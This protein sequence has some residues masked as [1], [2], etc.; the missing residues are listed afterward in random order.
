VGQFAEINLL[1]AQAALLQSPSVQTGGGQPSA[2]AS[3]SAGP[4]TH[5]AVEEFGLAFMNRYATRVVGNV[6]PTV[7]FTPVARSLTQFSHMTLV[8]GEN[9]EVFVDY[10]T[11]TIDAN[12][13]NS[14]PD[15]NTYPSN[16]FCAADWC[17]PEWRLPLFE[18]RSLGGG[19]RGLA[20]TGL[21]NAGTNMIIHYD[22]DDHMGMTRV[23]ME[24]CD[25][26][27][28]TNQA[29]CEAVTQVILPDGT[30]AVPVGNV[31]GLLQFYAPYAY[32]TTS[33][34]SKNFYTIDLWID[35]PEFR[36]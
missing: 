22:G 4:G 5:Y 36:R 2:P 26:P 13:F 20:A 30:A 8:Q 18:I 28:S 34:R 21:V 27:T 14:L 12:T 23:R 24:L 31:G 15:V 3:R 16:L 9:F 7:P 19:G 29:I 33:V 1:S 35:P 11:T 10:K 32:T 17:K 6:P 25:R